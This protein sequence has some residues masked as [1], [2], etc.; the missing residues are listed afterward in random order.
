MEYEIKGPFQKLR[1]K[2]HLISVV[3]LSFDVELKGDTIQVFFS[4][5]PV[6]GGTALADYRSK[7]H[8]EG[9]LPLQG[10]N[11]LE[12][13][14]LARVLLLKIGRQA[15]FAVKNV[16]HDYVDLTIPRFLR[17]GPVAPYG[18]ESSTESKR[19]KGIVL[20]ADLRGFSTWEST[21]PPEA[22]SELFE[23]FSERIVQM[24]VDNYYD[25][26]KLLGDGVMLVWEDGDC[27]D[28]TE[29]AVSTAF[30]LHKHYWY[31]RR[32]LDDPVP[33]G[34]GIAVAGGWL[35][36]YR[37]KTYAESVVLQDYLGSAITWAA[38]VQGLAKPGEVL[39]QKNI[40]RRL[41]DSRFTLEEATQRLSEAGMMKGIPPN[42]RELFRVHH[43]SF[44]DEWN[45]FIR[46]QAAR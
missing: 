33:D 4:D 23:V 31:F 14:E 9:L 29:L 44:G 3:R 39:V 45:T 19:T 15:P 34:F 32:D 30:D 11:S 20:M 46:P 18:T 6:T 38:R 2:N 42:Q 37:S 12:P 17:T 28:A 41:K 24:Q 25:Y 40:A 1:I 7:Q 35:T 8:G 10:F 43:R 26:W 16:E 22:V 27:T 5:L 13:E 21:A 36:S